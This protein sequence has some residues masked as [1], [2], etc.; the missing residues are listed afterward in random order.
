MLELFLTGRYLPVVID[1]GHNS[2]AKAVASVEEV[3]RDITGY[4]Q[5]IWR[6]HLRRG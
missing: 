5:L 3:A 6:K 4:V 2:K 1:N